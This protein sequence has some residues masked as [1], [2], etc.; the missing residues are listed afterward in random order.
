MKRNLLVLITYVSLSLA[1]GWLA[2]CGGG[3]GTTSTT[4]AATESSTGISTGTITGFGSV[5]VNGVRF[6]TDDA[7]VTRSGEQ[8]N[9]VRDLNEGMIVRV[10]GDLSNKVADNVSFEETVKGLVDVPP[11]GTTLTVMG[12]TVLTDASTVFNNNVILA[13]IAAGDLLEISGLRDANDN[14]LASFVERKNNPANVNR[15]NVT[16]NVRNLNTVTKRFQIGGL[17]VDYSAADVNDLAG[18]D[19][20]AG[21]LVEVKDDNKAYVAGSAAL[22]ATKV[23]P[24]GRLGGQAGELA[25]GV[26]IELESIITQLN[27]STEFVISGLTVQTTASTQFLFGTVD[28]LAVGARIEVE[29]TIDANGILQAAKIKFEDNDVRI[30]AFVDSVG[31]NS[32]TLLG[33]Q[34]NVTAQTEIEDKRDDLEPLT[35]S[36]IQPNDY[37]KIRGFTGA[38]GAVIATELEREDDDDD[39]RL[40]GTASQIDAIAGTV[41]ILGITVNTNGSTQF[42]GFD[43][44]VLTATQFFAA[45]TPGLTIVQVQW[46]PFTDVSLPARELELED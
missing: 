26:R 24:Q 18:G 14:I 32:V 39:V 20:T 17:T 9:D 7:V 21:Q 1:V 15:Y 28:N 38:D 33:I 43:D 45:V 8:V 3:G 34:V 12:Q 30:E 46:R 29:G 27:S 16:G 35:V 36:D 13:S 42:E 41:T 2:G 10:E 44:Q 19:P 4:P 11:S 5:F 37:L 31:S 25:G 23:E 40:R 22:T 6:N